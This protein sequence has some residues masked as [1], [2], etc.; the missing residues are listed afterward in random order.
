MMINNWLAAPLLLL[1]AFCFVPGM[2]FSATDTEQQV[3]GIV[4]EYMKICLFDSTS[5]FINNKE[6]LLL[7]IIF[8]VFLSVV[9]LFEL[10]SRI[11]PIINFHP[12][13][14]HNLYLIN[15]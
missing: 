11:F 1:S 8:T 15:E 6:Y 2:A 14:V 4:P 5:M 9:K 3:Q 10:F 12:T 13:E 7:S